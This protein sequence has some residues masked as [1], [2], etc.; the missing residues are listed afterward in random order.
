MAA[1]ALTTDHRRGIL[2]AAVGVTVL[3]FDALLVRLAA[4]APADVV[5]WRGLFIALALT[6]VFR[7]LRGRWTWTAVRAAGRS[8]ALLVL[9]MGLAQILFVAALKST[10]VANVVVMLAAAPLFAAIFS[11]VFLGEWVRTRTWAAMALCLVGI[12]LVFG[13]SIG[14]GNWLGDSLA[15][16]AAVAVGANF[17]I[18][19]RSPGVSRLAVIAGGSILACLAALPF[20][21]PA[22]IGTPALL[23]LAL[24]GLLQLPLALVMMTEAT[25]YL[26]SAEVALFLVIEAVL[27]TYWVWL[28]LGEEPPGATVLGG[29]LILATLTAH[30][31]LA[32]RGERPRHARP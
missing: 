21:E 16:A 23:W 15:L 31:W 20:A 24:M 27:G 14:T 30:S 32:L 1:L 17:T 7:L 8:G 26:P 9:S 11:G 29:A 5:F 18:L 4:S 2:L 22:A 10:S 19:R 12:G 28:V 6:A 25:R 13:G 3:S